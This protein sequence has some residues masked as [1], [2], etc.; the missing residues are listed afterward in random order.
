MH[1]YANIILAIK[2][3]ALDGVI[4]FVLILNVIQPSDQTFPFRFG[5]ELVW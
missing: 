1:I 4:A 3:P 2:N 5:K